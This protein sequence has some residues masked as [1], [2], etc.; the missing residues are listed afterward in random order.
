MHDRFTDCEEDTELRRATQRHTAQATKMIGAGNQQRRATASGEMTK[1]SQFLIIPMNPKTCTV[2]PQRSGDQRGARMAPPCV[3]APRYRLVLRSRPQAAGIV[4]LGRR[5][6]SAQL[7]RVLA[8][9]ATFS[10]RS[11]AVRRYFSRGVLFCAPRRV[12]FSA[13][14]CSGTGV[15]RRG[16]PRNGSI[17]ANG[18]RV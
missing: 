7:S 4:L 12:A 6:V 13:A 14:R 11:S 2:N 9:A 15:A 3:G 18:G 8:A 17:C 1:Q 10:L 16:T 5:V